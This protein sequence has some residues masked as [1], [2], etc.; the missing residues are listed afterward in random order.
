MGGEYAPEHEVHAALAAVK[1]DPS[2]EIIL[3][4]KTDIITS[5]LPDRKPPT[6]ITIVHASDVVS[7]SDEPSSI[8]KSRKDSSL[9]LG[10]D[11]MRD[12]KADAFVSAGNT[13]GVMATATMLCGRLRGVSRPTI[14]SFFP[15]E[16]GEPTL[17]VDVGANVDSKAK[18]LRDYAVMGSVYSQMILGRPNPTVGLLN[19]GEESSK[20]TEV[21]REAYELL[22]KAPINFVGNVEGRDILK[23]TVDVVV[24]DGFE[25]N[26][27]LKFAESVIG[28]LKSRF[29]TYADKSVVNKLVIGLFRPVLRKVLSGMDYQEY[30]GVPLLGINGVA[31]IGHGSSSA[32]AIENMIHRAAEIVRLDVNGTIQTALT[33]EQLDK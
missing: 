3:V 20:G 28:F 18:F 12:G 5:Y 24:C 8:V 2:I 1:S 16:R 26:I 22:S 11:L 14:G 13:G 4:G 17:V 23:G 31:I 32:M 30:G 19:V 33:E 6:N 7:M 9:Y 10:V 15:T 27:V 25:G 21:V 29:K